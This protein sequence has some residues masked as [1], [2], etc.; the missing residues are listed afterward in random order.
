MKYL[1][2]EKDNSL[3]SCCKTDDKEYIRIV[4]AIGLLITGTY[5]LKVKD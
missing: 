3:F 1:T 5:N 4:D 2:P